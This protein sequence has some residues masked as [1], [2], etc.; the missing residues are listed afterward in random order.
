MLEKVAIQQFSIRDQTG[1]FDID[2][3]QVDEQ[4]RYDQ[5]SSQVKVQ[6]TKAV[7]ESNRLKSVPSSDQAI[8]QVG[9]LAA[10]PEP[11][12]GKLVN[13]GGT[14]ISA[15]EKKSKGSKVSKKWS[16]A[17]IGILT[18]GI[19]IIAILTT[20]QSSKLSLMPTETNQVAVLETSVPTG[21]IQL[22]KTPIIT[23]A[24]IQ[25]RTPIPTLGISSTKINEDNVMEMVYVTEGEF[26]MGCD[27]VHNSG[28]SFE[29]DE[30]P[31]HTVYLDAYYI[32][33]YE[34][35]NAQYGECVAAGAC[36]VPNNESSYTRTTYYSNPTYANYPV[37]YVS[38]YDATNYCAWAD[39]RLPTEAEWEKA[40]RGTSPRAFPWGDQ[41]PTCTLVNGNVSGECVGDTSEV[42]SYSE[43]AS[44][45]GALDMAGN[46]WEWTN[47]WYS[48]DYY[49]VSPINNP[50]G[51]ATG[52]HKVFRGGSWNYAVFDVYY[53]R[54]SFRFFGIPSD[55]GGYDLGFR[56][57]VSP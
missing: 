27:P 55:R 26:Q 39:K 2:L 37:I 22:T 42:G 6:T 25:V 4:T 50:S 56:C 29:S 54:T 43:G 23:L 13:P 11:G 49:S 46:V 1:Y 10:K 47:D 3:D 40:A 44:P 15:L 28:Y 16:L 5:T 32:D 17:F 48:V 14:N 18:V 7:N 41:A 33:K 38:W 30:L 57:A 20:N 24:P 45:Y 36:S 21:A 35:T 52:N 8:D 9:S 12:M 34:V 19:T 53:M 31:L 51:P